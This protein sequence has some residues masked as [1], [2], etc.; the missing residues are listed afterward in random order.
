MKPRSLYAAVL[1]CAACSTSD[2]F[3]D[4][5][6]S[7]DAEPLA[8]SDEAPLPRTLVEA[9]V[10]TDSDSDT[11]TDTDT[12]DCEL[13]DEEPR[14]IE[15]KLDLAPLAMLERTDDIPLTVHNDHDEPGTVT[16]HAFVF[17]AHGSREV[18]EV[19]TAPVDAEGS[20][21]FDIPMAAL[22]LPT[23][24]LQ[25]SGRVVF[26]TELDLGLGSAHLPEQRPTRY[27]HPDPDGPG[28]L[29]Y[30]AETRDEAFDDGALTD[31][32]RR[33]ASEAEVAGSRI[34]DAHV[35]PFIAPG[36]D[37]GHP[38]DTPT[39][40]T[41]DRF[42]VPQRS[43]QS[44]T[45]N[46]CFRLETEYEDAGVGEDYWTSNL[47]TFREARGLYVRVERYTTTGWVSVFE[48]YTGDGIGSGDPGKGCTGDIA[49]SGPAI[50][51][52]TIWGKSKVQGNEIRASRPF[53]VP[54]GFNFW[55][56]DSFVIGDLDYGSDGDYQ[57]D[58][59]TEVDERLNVLMMVSYAIWRH[60]GN[61]SGHTFNV[62]VDDETKYSSS[63]GDLYIS[64][65]SSDNKFKGNHETGHAIADLTT[66]GV[67]VGSNYSIAN[68]QCPATADGDGNN[69]HSLLSR[70]Y[71][72]AAAN[73]GFAHFYSADVFNDHDETDCK[74]G[75]YKDEYGLP[76]PIAVD[77]ENANTISG[78]PFSVK[79]ME[80]ECDPGIS[81]PIGFDI[82][83]GSG[84]ELD[85][86]RAFWDVHTNGS[87]P[88]HMNTILDWLESA[89]EPSW[90]SAYDDLDEA[91]DDYG[92]VIRT[93]WNSAVNINGIDH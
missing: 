57:V 39:P 67:M 86:L 30:D 64:E 73:E 36:E 15:A 23:E 7:A 50:Y 34:V 44:A 14:V 9:A 81:L 90:T 17:S 2:A 91:A 11:D 45:V 20:V 32:A 85:W 52:H 18:R 24:P 79:F 13:S 19:A 92:G 10:E 25:R 65:A 72:E 77:C 22:G 63:S 71:V 38:D 3:P 82:F 42:A 43:T 5:E 4:D 16:V 58:I 76:L 47:P 41:I 83:G 51:R 62:R 89:D 78:N 48:N 12:D 49:S 66:D 40:D 8:F 6:S 27:F 68:S 35:R 69:H 55:L 59:S 54:G 46:F 80:S 84:V 31:E 74:F 70:E 56:L 93:N 26:T 87:N 29:L 61:I 53:P 37:E 60:A 88:P 21:D 28:W 1:L 33:I 75:Y